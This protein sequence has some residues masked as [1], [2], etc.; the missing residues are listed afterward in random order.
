MSDCTEK[1]KARLACD[2]FRRDLRVNVGSS[3][4]RLRGVAAVIRFTLVAFVPLGPSSK[5]YST[6]SPSWR[7]L[8]PW[9][10]ITEW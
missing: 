2:A 5:S 6:I 9:P 8:K 7:V 3:R 10:S 4:I 1:R